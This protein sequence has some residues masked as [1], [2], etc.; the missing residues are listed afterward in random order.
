M[1]LATVNTRAC[2]GLD[3]PLVRVEAHLSG[4]L[5]GMAIVGL[6]ETAVR[7]S[8]DRVRSA[9]L[10]SG[11]D[12]PTQRITINLSPADLPKVGGRFDLPIA[13]GILAASRQIPAISLDDHVFIGEL[14]LAGQLK[15]VQGVLSASLA[16]Q[17]DGHVLVLGRDNGDE[18]SLPDGARVLAA[19]T[20][21]ELVRHLQGRQPLPPLQ[22]PSPRSDVPTPAADLREVR[23]QAQARRALEISA[24]GGHSLLMEGP[25]GAGKT[26]LARCLPGLLPTLDADE[27]LEVT[28]LHGL[29]GLTRSDRQPPWRAP[30]HATPRGSLVGH[31]LRPGELSLAH[32][33][34]LFLDE[35][36]EFSRQTLEALR[37]PLESRC[38][39]VTTRHGRSVQYPAD[40]LL[41]AAM[42]PCPCGQR[43]LEGASCLC[44]PEQVGRYRAR[45]SAPLL[46]R[47]D[48]RVSLR[49][50]P[51][52]LLLG[53][54]EGECTATVQARVL[55]TRALQRAR[56][57]C[58]NAR[59]PGDALMQQ[60]TPAAS[61][62]L[63][64][65][66]SRLN[67]SARAWHRLVR[68][69]RTLA[70]M[71]GETNISQAALAEALGYR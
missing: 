60:L 69:A 49:P 4:G 41:V 34:V 70:D 9:L 45:L 46:D 53:L 64:Q 25:P 68:V 65:A 14:S 56:Q 61:Q 52:G 50:V 12:F 38:M 62:F 58:L 5:P 63:D 22:R 71:A 36:P 23:G 29:A 48:L 27:H 20:L 15:A 31:G 1:S 11:F 8:K 47:I 17:R 18:A 6:P 66:A 7:E 42:N 21:T 37:E 26:L 39:P 35:L 32:R 57:G 2:L 24:S 59:L 30:H 28:A 40:C 44:T 51:A 16:C 19:D 13:L 67:L 43:G 10:N 33:G 54:P 55:A 3:A